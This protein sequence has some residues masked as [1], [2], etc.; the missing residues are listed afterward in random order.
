MTLD[1]T[2]NKYQELC[3]VI[4]ES[5][6]TLLTLDEYFSSTQLPDKFII[7]RH[8][9][10]DEPEYSLKMA[11]LEHDSNIK[12]TYYFRTTENVFKR[13]TIKKICSLGHEVGYHY[14]VLDEAAGN[15]VKAIEIFEQNLDKFRQ[16]CDVKTIAQ[17]GSPLIGTLNATSVSGIYGIIKNI[18][19]GNKVFTNWINV[20]IWNEYDF[21]DFGIM[22]EAY[23]SMDF[24][25]VFYLSDT[26]MSWNNRYRI[27]DVVNQ[28][29]P[30]F[31]MDLK[32]SNTNDI[33]NMIK[34]GKVNHIYL[35]VHADQWRD[36]R[37][38]WIKW[39]TLKHIR[40]MGKLGLKCYNSKIEKK[41]KSG[42]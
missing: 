10:D 20:D 7:I 39:S 2:L 33:M 40:N 16:V 12:S 14:E 35:L 5:K 1:F 4:A 36:K 17:H 3:N 22:G 30:S 9:V 18:I 38:D 34:S 8:D 29:S 37:S 23:I 26:G 15:Y 21:T 28:T 31:N 6:Y 25:N 11:Q 13:E 42:V 27:K 32:V 24:N 41:T 19:R